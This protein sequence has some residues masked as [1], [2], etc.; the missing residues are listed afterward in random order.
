LAV[1]FL[2][3][4][5]KKYKQKINIYP[6]FIKFSGIIYI[7]IKLICFSNMEDSMALER[8]LLLWSKENEGAVTESLWD[9]DR[10]IE[11]P[12]DITHD[13]MEEVA[14]KLSPVI[15]EEIGKAKEKDKYLRIVQLTNQA[16][17]SVLLKV[18]ESTLIPSGGE[19]FNLK[20]KKKS[21]DAPTVVL[22]DATAAEAILNEGIV[23]F[24]KEPLKDK[25][26]FNDGIKNSISPP[27]GWNRK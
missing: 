21:H 22:D 11:V 16:F 8:T 18:L 4:F 9:S 25:C 14:T 15:F 2:F 6:L 17:I 10:V 19:L 5:Y 3:N 23:D 24:D 12:D 26:I 13:N 7:V 27:P 1:S 20:I